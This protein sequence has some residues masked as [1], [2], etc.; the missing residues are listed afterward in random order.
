MRFTMEKLDYFPHGRTVWRMLWV[1]SGCKA[2]LG[3]VGLEK[4]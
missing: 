4:L 1:I 2:A 3:G